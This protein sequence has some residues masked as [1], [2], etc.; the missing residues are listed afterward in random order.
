MVGD[1][2]FFQGR[3]LEIVHFITTEIQLYRRKV[4]TK[5]TSVIMAWDVIQSSLVDCKPTF[6]ASGYKN[7]DSMGK[8]NQQMHNAGIPT[9]KSLLIAD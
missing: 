2:H 7:M 5:C 8:M 3:S 6:P 4:Y 1:K 9:L